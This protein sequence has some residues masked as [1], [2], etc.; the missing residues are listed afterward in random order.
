MQPELRRK[1]VQS[2]GDDSARRLGHQARNRPGGH[3]LA[4]TRLADDSQCLASLEFETD[5]IYCFDYASSCIEVGRK[6]LNLQY[7]S[8]PHQRYPLSNL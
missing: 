8:V 2:Y 5:S 1:K 3:T 7:W 6:V 4:R